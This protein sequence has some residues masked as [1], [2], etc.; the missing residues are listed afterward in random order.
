MYG[1]LAGYGHRPG[2]LIVIAA[3]VWLVCGFVYSYAEKENVFGPTNPG[4]FNTPKLADKCRSFWTRCKELPGEYP[5]FSPF[6]YSLDRILPVV[7]LGQTNS[8]GPIATRTTDRPTSSEHRSGGFLIDVFSALGFARWDL[9][10][11]VRFI[12][13]VEIIIGWAAGLTLA[14]I[15]SGTVKRSR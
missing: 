11:L 3:W 4:I 7:S 14:G 12:G 13:W 2:R 8:W 9:G 1:R 6:A 5:T 10:S 15:V